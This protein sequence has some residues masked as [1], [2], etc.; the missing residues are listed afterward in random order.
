[1]A[2]EDRNPE[3]ERD[4]LLLEAFQ[5]GKYVT[6]GRGIQT[7]EEAERRRKQAET[8]RTQVALAV[9]LLGSR[10]MARGAIGPTASNR[11]VLG[12][13]LAPGSD[14]GALLGALTPEAHRRGWT[15]H[16]VGRRVTEPVRGKISDVLEKAYADSGISL[17][18]RN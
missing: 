14:A 16:Q 5:S 18:G 3:S 17:W 13:G 9:A 11:R 6:T 1:M 10:G 4:R 2:Y 7:R 8:L 15:P 12:A